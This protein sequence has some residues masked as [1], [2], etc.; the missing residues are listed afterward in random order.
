MSEVELYE[1]F[2]SSDKKGKNEM[3]LSSFNFIFVVL[4]VV[5]I[6]SSIGRV[7]KSHPHENSF[8]KFAWCVKLN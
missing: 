3:L 5:K 4:I 6:I 2:V 7:L 8:V 1:D